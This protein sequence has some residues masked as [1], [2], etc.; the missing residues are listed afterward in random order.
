MAV[1]VYTVDRYTG[2]ESTDPTFYAQKKYIVS[3]FIDD[4]TH[5]GTVIFN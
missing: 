2:I 5:V 4:P 3:Y 1:V